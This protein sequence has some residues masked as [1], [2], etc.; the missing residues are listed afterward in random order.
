MTVRCMN[1]GME[2]RELKAGTV[3]GIHQP[4][5]EDQIKASDVQAKSVLPGA[6]PDLCS[7]VHFMPDRC[8]NRR[9]RYAKP[10]TSL[11]NWLAC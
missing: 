3:I 4:V 2:P 7:N 5:K 8:W 1:L 6:C 9:V 10:T 11:L